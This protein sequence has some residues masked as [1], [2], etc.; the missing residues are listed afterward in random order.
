MGPLVL[1]S[2]SCLECSG[3][4]LELKGSG[5]SVHGSVLQM[6]LI[7]HKSHNNEK[8]IE[9]ETSFKY[10][11]LLHFKFFRDVL[12]GSGA[13]G[14]CTYSPTAPAILCTN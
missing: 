9:T 10:R 7:T 6:P 3:F 11:G 4:R 12:G 1:A 14:K 8:E 5:S 2:L 13:F